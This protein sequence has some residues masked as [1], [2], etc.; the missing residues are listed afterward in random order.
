MRQLCTF[1]GWNLFGAELSNSK[2]EKSPVPKRHNSIVVDL[3]IAGNWC[4]YGK[5]RETVS[6]TL[7]KWS[8]DF[9]E[10]GSLILLDRHLVPFRN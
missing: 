9:L 1:V 7:E 5:L 10:V 4:L 6:S 2:E 3:D 8:H